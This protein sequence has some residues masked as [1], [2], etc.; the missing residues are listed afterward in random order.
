[1]VNVQEAKTRL[2]ELLRSVERGEEVVIARAGRE[3]ARLQAVEPRRRRF[4]R[5]L[6]P[7][8]P[9]ADDEAVLSAMGED[10]LTEWENG[11]PGDP[12]REDLA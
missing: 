7:G 10:E 4:D 5:P 3:I 12:L 1:M 2:S 9:A 6:L 8:I 11:H